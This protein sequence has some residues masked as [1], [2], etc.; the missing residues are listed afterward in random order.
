M[1][2][3][4]PGAVYASP[5]GLRWTA[6]PF[7]PTSPDDTMPT[8]AWD[9]RLGKYVIYVRRDV[10]QGR[11]IGRCV[12]SNISDWQQ[13]S[14]GG[15]LTVFSADSSEPPGTDIYSNSYAPSQPCQPCPS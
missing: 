12:T 8:A 6:L 2:C 14:E 15:C 3:G 10:A 4:A 11:S 1:V 7:A 9:P 5:N 13:E